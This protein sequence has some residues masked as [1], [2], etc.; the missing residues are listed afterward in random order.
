MLVRTTYYTPCSYYIEPLEHTITAQIA[1]YPKLGN[2]SYLRLPINATMVN[3]ILE[4][5][6]LR[7]G[8]EQNH[9]NLK[10]IEGGSQTP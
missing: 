6:N 10:H 8:L 1:K 9:F 2:F 7:Q 5:Q 3:L 4:I